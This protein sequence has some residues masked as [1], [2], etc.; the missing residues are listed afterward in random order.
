[1]VFYDGA[2]NQ[3]KSMLKDMQ[4]AK[5]SLSFDFIDTDT[6]I[7]IKFNRLQDDKKKL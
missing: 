1:M 4:A 3:L 7:G 2:L 6:V 5:T